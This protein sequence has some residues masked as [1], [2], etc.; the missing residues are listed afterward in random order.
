M[1][2]RIIGFY[3]PTTVTLAAT[4][5]YRPEDIIALKDHPEIPTRYQPTRANM[6]RGLSHHLSTIHVEIK[7][8]FVSWMH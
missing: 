2:T 6:V 4:Y 5:G 8:R 7:H 3:P 1:I